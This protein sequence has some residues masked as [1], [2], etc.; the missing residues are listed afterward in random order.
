MN[1]KEILNRSGAIRQYI[2]EQVAKDPKGIT[3]S[4]VSQFKISRQA[5]TRYLKQMVQDGQLKAEGTTKNRV[6]KVQPSQKTQIPI[7][8]EKIEEF[9]KLHQINE[10]SLFGSV[11]RNGF[12]PESDVDVLVSFAS[13][14]SVSLIDLV[15]MKEELKDL[16]KR[17]VDLVEKEALTNPF[18]R[19]SILSTKETI[20]A[21]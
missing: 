10:F 19:Y 7:P 12:R 8:L 18:L 21:S 20:Y 14:T 4:I 13:D 6:Y 3:A 1:R 9:C 11:L 15:E 17:D 16:F 5:A 2:L